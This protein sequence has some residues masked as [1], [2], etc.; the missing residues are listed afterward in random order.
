MSISAQ[1]T[2][3]AALHQDRLAARA[4]GTH[5]THEAFWLSN[6]HTR[7]LVDPLLCMVLTIV[8]ALSTALPHSCVRKC[9]AAQHTQ[10][11]RG[12]CLLYLACD[13]FLTAVTGTLSNHCTTAETGRL[14]CLA[15]VEV[16][17]LYF[18]HLFH[19]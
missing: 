9:C 3:S 19:R 11:P 4:T 12:S 18:H 5:L 17:T 16:L 13:V 6:E 1:H 8:L 10:T 2:V 14:A 7:V 15:S